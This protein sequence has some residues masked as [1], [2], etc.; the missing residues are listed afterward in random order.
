[1]SEE[2]LNALLA[3]LKDD[4]GLREKLRSVEDLDDL[5]AIAKDA[6]FRCCTTGCCGGLGSKILPPVA[7]D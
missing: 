1:M 3:K 7:V 5:V 4:A 2:Q 6:I